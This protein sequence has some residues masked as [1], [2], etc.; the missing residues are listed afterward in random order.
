[1]RAT[2]AARDARPRATRA[3]AGG[4]LLRGSRCAGYDPPVSTPSWPSWLKH[5]ASGASGPD[6]PNADAG[7]P[8]PRRLRTRI[9]TSG[10]P[11]RSDAAGRRAAALRIAA[12]TQCRCVCSCTACRDGHTVAL[13]SAAAGASSALRGRHRWCRPDRRPDGRRRVV[14]ALRSAQ[15]L[16]PCCC[17]PGAAS[18]SASS[19]PSTPAP[20]R[21]TAAKRRGALAR[22]RRW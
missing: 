22:A 10:R 4:R 2:S 12:T 8:L 17:S 19:R 18:T 3:V 1:M 5:A 21:P 11:G 15:P 20:R 16:G 6:A 7:P 9:W 13:A 14:Q